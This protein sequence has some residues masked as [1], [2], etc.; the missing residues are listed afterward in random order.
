MSMI[1]KIL[2]SY[3]PLI[4]IPVIITLIAIGIVLSGGLQEG[5]DLKGGSIA[6]L[7]LEQPITN[8]QL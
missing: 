7:Q 2:D 5:I 8:D 1:D 4:I 6:I 3:K